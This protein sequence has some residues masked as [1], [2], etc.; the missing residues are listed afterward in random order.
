[1][2]KNIQIE[3]KEGDITFNFDFTT[4]FSVV[5]NCNYDVSTKTLSINYQEWVEFRIREQ[6]E[7][8][9]W[10]M[11]STKTKMPN[12]IMQK[13][14]EKLYTFCNVLNIEVIIDNN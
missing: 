10:R 8:G 13:H 12:D 7:N 3:K 14:M 2:L 9:D 5:S 6:T 4:E 11:E 1:M